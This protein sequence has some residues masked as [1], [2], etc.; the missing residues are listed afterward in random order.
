LVT[1]RGSSSISTKPLQQTRHSPLVN[2]ARRH[3]KSARAAWVI[4][5]RWAG[6]TLTLFLVVCGLTGSMLAFYEELLHA[7]APWTRVQPPA[8]DARLLDPHTLIAAAERA[9]PEAEFTR[10]ELNIEPGKALVFFPESQ[11][12]AALTFDELALNPYTG[13][14]VYRGTWAALSEGMHQIMPFVFRVHYTLALGDIGRLMLGI[15][16]LVWTLDCFIGFYLTLPASRKRWLRRWRKAWQF[17]KP[18]AHWYRFNFSLHRAGG[19]WLWPILLVFAWSSV[20]FNLTEVYNPI[21]GAMGG[22]DVIGRLPDKPSPGN[23]VHDWP[24]KLE[25]A[26]S[27]AAS[28]G[29]NLGFTVAAEDGLTYRSASDSYE[30]RYR[31]STDLPSTRAQSRLYFDRVSGAL[32]AY[33]PGT[34]QLSADGIEEWLVAL[35]I[36]SIGGLPY[37]LFVAVLGVAIAVLAITGVL[38]WMR[39]RSARIQRDGRVSRVPDL[40]VLR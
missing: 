37:R 38:I 1:P 16:A 6:L 18:S 10:L 2:S 8:P 36:A 11:S 26:R 20:G 25:Q 30:Y 29:Q 27:I 23:L 34:G 31:G 40:H 39:K 9:A 35:H 24:A 21:M 32:I 19:L 14:E 13:E 17:R 15:A 28:H 7:T 12:E 22:S 4:V 33:K 3:S 5:H